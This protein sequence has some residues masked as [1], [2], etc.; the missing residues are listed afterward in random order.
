MPSMPTKSTQTKNFKEEISTIE[1]DI[2]AE[3]VIKPVEMV[4]FKRSQF[5]SVLTIFAF[6][7]GVLLGYVVWGFD[8][9][10]EIP[11]VS[12]QAAG[13]VIEAPV[14]EEP[15]RYDVASDGFPSIGPEDAPITIVEF[16][17]YQCPYCTRWHE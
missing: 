9:V 16:S 2:F 12:A 7:V 10:R 1:T 6:A 3:P 14:T 4:S 8:T 13:P 15:H 11:V 5:Y 17:D